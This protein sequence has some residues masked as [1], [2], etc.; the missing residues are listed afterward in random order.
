MPAATALT[1]EIVALGG[2][3]GSFMEIVEGTLPATS[4]ATFPSKLSSVVGGLIQCQGTTA[5][6]TENALSLASAPGTVSLAF[7]ATAF[8][9]A[10]FT[11]VLFGKR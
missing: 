4:P 3:L 10:K 1:S 9:S 5:A 2:D 8:A 11:A 7:D 6:A